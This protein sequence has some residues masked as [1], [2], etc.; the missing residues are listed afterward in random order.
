ML[1]RAATHATRPTS[2]L[3]AARTSA[4][5]VDAVTVEDAVEEGVPLPLPPPLD[6]G[7]TVAVAT[8]EFAAADDAEDP[9]STVVVEADAETKVVVFNIMGPPGIAVVMAEV[10]ALEADT[11]GPPGNA[12][13]ITEVIAAAVVE[14]AATELVIVG[15]TTA[16]VLLIADVVAG[17]PEN[18]FDTEPPTHWFNCM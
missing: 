3:P 18:V 1:K 14:V 17:A 16:V 11:M 2:C 12:D 8:V 6:D 10:L 9:A 13:V 7:V 5:P 15:V 4:A